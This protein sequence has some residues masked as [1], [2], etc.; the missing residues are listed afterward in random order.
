VMLCR[1][2]RHQAVCNFAVPPFVTA[3]LPARVKPGSAEISCPLWVKSRHVRRKKPCP[4][5]PRK[6][7][8]AVQLRMSAK[9]QSG[10]EI[11]SMT[12]PAGATTDGGIVR[13]IAFAVRMFNP[14]V[15]ISPAA[16]LEGQRG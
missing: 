1:P 2:V 13:P 11:Y 5:Y 16:P 10:H 12:S 7:T 8:C 3:L 14:G 4:L 15:R 6:R 9:A